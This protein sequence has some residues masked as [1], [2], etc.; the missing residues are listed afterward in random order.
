MSHVLSHNDK[1]T[2]YCTHIIKGTH[3][4]LLCSNLQLC[5]TMTHYIPSD[6]QQYG[7]TSGQTHSY[8][9]STSSCICNA[10]HM[11]TVQRSILPQ[12]SKRQYLS[13]L[14][15]HCLVLLETGLMQCSDQQERHQ[16]C[17]RAS[18]ARPSLHCWLELTMTQKQTISSHLPDIM[19]RH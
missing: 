7:A 12:K 14:A 9:A 1:N 17:V 13:A 11:S 8:T 2:L 15:L 18:I 19:S 16:R 3:G 10:V 5:Q 6:A 4:H